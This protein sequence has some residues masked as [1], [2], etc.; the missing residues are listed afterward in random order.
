MGGSERIRQTQN[1]EGHKLTWPQFLTAQKWCS[2]WLFFP[3]AFLAGRGLS[4]SS[5]GEYLS[6]LSQLGQ[7]MTLGPSSSS[8]SGQVSRVK[9]GL[10]GGGG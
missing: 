1:Q 6:S 5:S 9:P 7:T 2:S 8:S 4:S 3:R 10:A